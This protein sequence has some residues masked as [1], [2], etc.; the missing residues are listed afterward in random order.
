M[1]PGLTFS[2]NMLRKIRSSQHTSPI[3]GIFIGIITVAD[4]QIIMLRYTRLFLRFRLYILM[5]R[6][7]YR[8]LIYRTADL[9]TKSNPPAPPPHLWGRHGGY[10]KSLSDYAKILSISSSK[11]R[12][13]KSYTEL[14][15]K[16]SDLIFIVSD[17][18]TIVFYIP[19][20]F[21]FY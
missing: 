16:Y 4:N 1:L 9:K 13:K 3:I 17:L 19:F 8:S 18:F 11:G 14:T 20:C 10:K 12:K 15:T 21:F 5:E 2:K 7:Q 6:R